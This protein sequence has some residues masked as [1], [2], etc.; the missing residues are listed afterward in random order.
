[1]HYVDLLDANTC[2]DVFELAVD[3][4]LIHRG[5]DKPKRDAFSSW[6]QEMKTQADQVIG[7][8][9]KRLIVNSKDSDFVK[10]REEHAVKVISNMFAAARAHEDYLG[11]KDKSVGKSFRWIKMPMPRRQIFK[12]DV[13]TSPMGSTPNSTSALALTKNMS[14]SE[15]TFSMVFDMEVDNRQTA[16]HE[17]PNATLSGTF[18]SDPTNQLSMFSSQAPFWD[19]MNS[20]S[21][22]NDTGLPETPEPM[23]YLDPRLLI[24][25]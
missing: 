23:S 22:Y 14:P 5:T 7:S 16:N 9:N 4:L 17:G 24:L 3:L 19:H 21:G 11:K 25:E 12:T 18:H 13:G 6:I 20:L 10:S 1:L 8:C 15:N 2:I